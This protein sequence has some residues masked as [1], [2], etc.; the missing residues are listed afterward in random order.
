MSDPDEVVI[1]FLKRAPHLEGC[2][3]ISA[4]AEN[5]CTC[6]LTQARDH[7]G[8]MQIECDGDCDTADDLRTDLKD[9]ESDLQ[10]LGKN[11]REL[12]DK[13]DGSCTRTKLKEVIDE[14]VD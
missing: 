4:D 1:E 5:C 2:V 9:V 10:Q 8:Y 3:A 13:T 11:L 12:L 14:Y 7:A 6:G